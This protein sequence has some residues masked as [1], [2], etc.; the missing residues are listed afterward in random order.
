MQLYKINK[1]TKKC[2]QV[3]SN[4]KINKWNRSKEIFMYNAINIS[5]EDL[6]AD[7]QGTWKVGVNITRGW[8]VAEGSDQPSNVKTLT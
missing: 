3:I 6:E 8:L 7:R 5:Q 4:D 2:Q 1:T